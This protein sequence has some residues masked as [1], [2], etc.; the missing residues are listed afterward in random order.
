MDLI[1][2][3]YAEYRL[4]GGYHHDQ[5]EMEDGNL[6][7]LTECF[8]NGTVEDMCVL[9][10]RAD[11]SILKPGTS[12]IFCL[13]M[14]LLPEAGALTTGSTIM[15]CGMIKRRIPSHYPAAIRMS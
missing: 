8:E 6:L 3:I 13:R 15:P 9:I 12:R 5:F 2:K 4:P 1:G 14:P 10:D 11:G 7:V